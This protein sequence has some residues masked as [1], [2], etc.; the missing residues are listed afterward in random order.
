MATSSNHP[1]FPSRPYT[2]GLS[3]AGASTSAQQNTFNTPAGFG[4]AATTTQQHREAQRI[5]RERADR[6]ERERMERAGQNQLAELSEEQREEI[7]EAVRAPYPT[8][9]P[10]N[11]ARLPGTSTAILTNS[12]SLPSSTSTKT[13]TS[14]TTSSKSP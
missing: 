7:N 13:A 12:P 8:T 11:F 14:T 2:T 3:R 9:P 4:S 6:A 5:E 1:T 10:A